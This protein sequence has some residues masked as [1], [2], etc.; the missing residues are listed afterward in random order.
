MKEIESIDEVLEEMSRDQPMPSGVMDTTGYGPLIFECG[1]GEYH[2]VNDPSVE[3]IASFRPV[4]ILFKCKSHYTKVRIK[5]IL[6]QKCI[7]EWTC[8]NKLLADF[9]KEKNL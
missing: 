1:C 8:L 7:S 9:V 2:G 6:T 3:Q 4:K 5:G